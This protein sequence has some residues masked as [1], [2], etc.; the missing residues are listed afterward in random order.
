[1]QWKRWARYT[2]T[3]LK[4]AFI[5]PIWGLNERL[6]P[7]S[8]G[9]T[10]LFG[11]FVG[12]LTKNPVWG[13]VGLL[14]GLLLLAFI[15]VVIAVADDA[16]P[17]PATPVSTEH[18]DDL[19]TIAGTFRRLVQEAGISEQ[20]DDWRALAGHFGEVADQLHRCN[21]CLADV[22]E[23]KKELRNL[24]GGMVDNSPVYDYK[25]DTVFEFVVKTIER[26]AEIPNGLIPP[27]SIH[28]VDAYGFLHIT[29]NVLPNETATLS[30]NDNPNLS[31]LKLSVEQM[32]DDAKSSVEAAAVAQAV[33]DL[34]DSQSEAAR[35]L[36][37]TIRRDVIVGTC[38]DC[39]V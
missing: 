36:D 3:A 23:R 7:L 26:L 5:R 16:R 15:A 10:I 35:S 12:F 9:L 32:M 11:L 34:H 21:L 1:M 8:A 6:G 2:L 13:L 27:I 33:R 30:D 29:T 38:P 31:A 24:I 20:S 22:A 37:R 25:R 18:R 19:K 39:A 17:V 4:V 28:W 14:A